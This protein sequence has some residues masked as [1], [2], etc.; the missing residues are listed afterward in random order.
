V[1]SA[2][3]S[4]PKVKA[5][6]QSCSDFIP[7]SASLKDYNKSYLDKHKSQPQHFLSTLRASQVL[8]PSSGPQ[9][10]KEVKKILEFKDTSLSD[11]SD[12]I[13]LLQNLKSHEDVV[14][15]FKAAARKNWP[16]ATAFQQSK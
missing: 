11:V 1:D 12:A 15:G 2:D 10:Q 3:I 5:V 13:E 14:E 4:D 16:E 9:S 8:D 6:L 7:K